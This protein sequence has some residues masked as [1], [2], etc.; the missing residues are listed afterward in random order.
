MFFSFWNLFKRAFVVLIYIWYS[1]VFPIRML[2]HAHFYIMYP[3]AS[4]PPPHTFAPKALPIAPDITEFMPARATIPCSPDAI[5][6]FA[7]FLHRT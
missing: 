6:P 3:R 2:V 1:C 7:S 4:D 5:L